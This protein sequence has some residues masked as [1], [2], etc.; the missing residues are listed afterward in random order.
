VGQRISQADGSIK[1][2]TQGRKATQASHDKGRL[3]PMGKGILPRAL[4]HGPAQ[5][6]THHLV[7]LAGQ[8]NGMMPR[9]TGGIEHTVHAVVLE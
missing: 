7:P 9:A 2:L 6:G 8:G 5:V 4:D 3:Y 1:G